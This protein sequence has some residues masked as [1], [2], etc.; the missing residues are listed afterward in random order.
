MTV[1]ERIVDACDRF[2]AAWRQGARPRIEDFVEDCTD[3]ELSERVRRLLE[4]ELELRRDRGEDPTSD[5]YAGRFPDHAALVEEL[6]ATQPGYRRPEPAATVGNQDSRST[7]VDAYASTEVWPESQAPTSL[8]ETPSSG[9]FRIVQFHARGNLGEVYLGHDEELHREVAVKQIQPRYAHDNGSRTRFVLEAEVTG[10]LEHPGIVPIYGLGRRANGQLFYAMRFIRG[11]SL[12]QAIARLHDAEASQR[13]VGERSLALRGL[14]RRFID[15]CNA[16]AYAHSRGVIHRDL[17]PGNIMLGPFGETLVVDW[18]LAKPLGKVSNQDEALPPW[19]PSPASGSESTEAGCAVGTPQFMSPEQAEGSID[20]LTPASD[21]YS[22]GAVL[23]AILTGRAPFAGAEPGDVLRRVAIGEFPAPRSVSPKLPAALDAVCIKAMSLRPQDRYDSATALAEDVERWLAD[24]PVLARR[25]PW[26][27]RAARWSRTHRPLVAGAAALLITATVALSV[28][29]VLIR[30]E[31][32]KTASQRNAAQD[33]AIQANLQ[34]DRAVHAEKA[35]RRLLASSY[36][37]AARLASQRGAWKDALMNYDKALATG[38]EDSV[39]IRLAKIEAWSACDDQRAAFREIESLAR[40]AD[41]G[42]YHAQVLLWQADNGR[43]RDLGAA[44]RQDLARKALAEGLPPADQAYAQSLLAE[45]SAESVKH[46][47]RVLE[48]DPY[49]G[50]ATNALGSLLLWLGR[51]Q[52][53][54]DLLGQAE[55]LFPD[56]PRIMTQRAQLLAVEGDLTA[57]KAKL[58]QIVKGTHAT[59]GKELEFMLDFTYGYRDVDAVMLDGRAPANQ[60]ARTG[61]PSFWHYSHV[62]G[63]IAKLAG[64]VRGDI[65][66]EKM[67]VATFPPHM[68]HAMRSFPLALAASY[69]GRNDGLLRASAELYRVHPEGVAAFYYG[70]RL[71]EAGRFEEAERVLIEGARLP[72]FVDCP[73]MLRLMTLVVEQQLLN[74]PN[75]PAELLERVRGNIRAFMA[76]NP[77]GDISRHAFLAGLARRISDVELERSIAVERARLAPADPDA[78][79]MLASVELRGKSHGNAITLAR[80]VLEQAPEHKAARAVLN[81]A[82]PKLREQARLLAPEQAPD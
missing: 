41:L 7:R 24:E 12:K 82:I 14:L 51:R 61:G 13:D 32:R 30:N 57:A 16:M 43:S 67:N 65:D 78:L 9:R 31:Q 5:E 66:P 34:A 50:R 44:D 23:Y 54:R 25:E 56:D 4:L 53:L 8:G 81:A 60:P 21:I 52:E 75:P 19:M 63:D 3:P 42:R 38:Y 1:L 27:D 40:R 28:G 74:Q 72:Q 71:F 69:L 46:L 64:W 79:A 58:Q 49:H 33:A 35:T 2:E 36:A 37:D 77:P 15:V 29:N 26:P 73:R 22:L 76:I 6:I 59:L 17:K 48:I 20:R 47:R 45:T 62:I 70:S 39:G 10:A 80:R 55:L 18:G 68:V 11:E